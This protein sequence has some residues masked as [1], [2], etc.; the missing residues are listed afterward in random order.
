MRWPAATL[1]LGPH[2]AGPASREL[3]PLTPPT[4]RLPTH[5]NPAQKQNTCAALRRM[6]YP[7]R[8]CAPPPPPPHPTPRRPH[9]ESRRCRLQAPHTHLHGIAV[10][11]LHSQL[12]DVCRRRE[13]GPAVVRSGRARQNSRQAAA[14]HG[15]EE[16][17]TWG[18]GLSSRAA[19]GGPCSLLSSRAG[20]AACSAGRGGPAVLA[21][22]KE[23][24][25][26]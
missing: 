15:A 2:R 26:A 7:G 9:L 25:Q 5:C 10:A 8:R 23:G 3:P 18:G 19:G 6:V 17:A 12:Q 13:A 21:C 11:R 14:A 16:E 22:Y 20:R 4:K 24:G 1:L